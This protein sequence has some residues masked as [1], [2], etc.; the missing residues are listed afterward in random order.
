MTP[1]HRRN[2]TKSTILIAGAIF[3]VAAGLLVAFLIGMRGLRPDQLNPQSIFIDPN[4]PTA[5]P[6]RL[7][8]TATPVW[9]QTLLP[10]AVIQTPTLVA[11]IRPSQTPTVTPT[12]IRI[13]NGYY[14]VQPSDTLE[15]AAA[16]LDCSVD[17]LRAVNFMYGDGIIQ[18]QHLRI[19]APGVDSSHFAFRFSSLDKPSRDS[20]YPL[21]Y[22]S[23]RFAI[24]Y[25]KNTYASVDLES[26]AGMIER[27]M[28]SV[29]NT[30]QQPLAGSFDAYAAG[31]LY[32]PPQTYLKGLSASADRYIFLLHDGGGDAYDQEYMTA[33]ELTHLYA[34]NTFG[35]P[36]SFLV[37]EGAAVYSGMKSISNPKQ[38]PIMGFCQ[39]FYQAGRLPWVGGLDDIASWRGHNNN[40]ENYYTAGCLVQYLIETYGVEKF[41][42]VY[43]S[44][45]YA[46]IYGKD[47]L[48][49]EGEFRGSF[50]RI[51]PLPG[52]DARRL[53]DSTDTYI[54]ASRQ[55]F[56][57]FNASSQHLTAYRWLNSARVAL[58]EGQLDDFDRSLNEF[59]RWFR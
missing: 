17:E 44:N 50:E 29:E 41:A 46:T 47:L 15:T 9:T 57:Y 3:L 8:E 19:P 27:S 55:F 28:A 48:A 20:S 43:S 26:L 37:S 6:F 30:F 10:T 16:Y 2:R 24:H 1:N 58:V 7:P 36:V 54:N 59:N 13:E 14:I 5:T 32:E 33:H 39:A 31:S 35:Q 11:T 21:I 18:G 45:D 52:V 22:R 12:P 40:L 51:E 38:I 23:G 53:V 42:A 56:A 49:L 4:L 34:W 25:A